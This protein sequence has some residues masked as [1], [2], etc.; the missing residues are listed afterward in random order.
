MP[1]ASGIG[2]QNEISNHSRELNQRDDAEVAQRNTLQVPDQFL[3][4]LPKTDRKYS[5]EIP[6]DAEII[7][8]IVSK[9]NLR[10]LATT[11]SA[12]IEEIP[13]GNSLIKLGGS[14]DWI[15][16]QTIDSGTVGFVFSELVQ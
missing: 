11:K 7:M 10:E 2:N 9:A 4:P 13:Y 6:D 12:I 14:G 1:S 16:V 3:T 8:V 15:K 5:V